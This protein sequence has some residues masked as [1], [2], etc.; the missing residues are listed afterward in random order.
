[1][2][3]PPSPLF[4][5]AKSLFGR[6]LPATEPDATDDFDPGF[7]QRL[8]CGR[9]D[10]FAAIYY[11]RLLGTLRMRFRTGPVLYTWAGVPK[12]V[13]DLMAKAE[14]KGSFYHLRIRGNY[15]TDYPNDR[16]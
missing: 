10:C 8:D 3:P 16:G 11:D 6:S 13:V 5:Q 4:P 14:S 15:T 9:S 12:A 1:M 7:L 2:L